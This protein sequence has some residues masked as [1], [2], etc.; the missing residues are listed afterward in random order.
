MAAVLP[1][2]PRSLIVVD[3]DSSSWRRV[4][5]SASGPT[6]WEKTN[7]GPGHSP[8]VDRNFGPCPPRRWIAA[9]TLSFC[10]LTPLLSAGHG[11]AFSFARTLTFATCR[12]EGPKQDQA[13][14]CRVQPAGRY[15]ARVGSGRAPPRAPQEGSSK[16]ALA[17]APPLPANRTSRGRVSYRRKSPWRRTSHRKRRQR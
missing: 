4:P 16:V 8:P 5:S 1:T 15:A 12:Q 11:K 3:E 6:E 2:S 17:R 10:C 9:G 14:R 13:P 7:K